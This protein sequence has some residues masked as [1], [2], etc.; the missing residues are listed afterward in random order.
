LPAGSSRLA[1][2]SKGEL[3]SDEVDSATRFMTWNKGRGTG[4][5]SAPVVLRKIG[6]PRTITVEN[7]NK[8]IG[9]IRLLHGTHFG[10]TL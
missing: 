4:R 6:I 7:F 8:R 5:V 9:R 10:R 2:S 1:S 3:I